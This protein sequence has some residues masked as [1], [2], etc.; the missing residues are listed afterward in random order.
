MSRTGRRR[1]PGLVKSIKRNAQIDATVQSF[2]SEAYQKRY[3]RQNDA[4]LRGDDG[5]IQMS[6]CQTATIDGEGGFKLN[7]HDYTY[8]K[9]NTREVRRRRRNAGKNLMRRQLEDC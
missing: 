1:D 6:K 8:R 5:A 7:G 4:I 9:N 2:R 3:Q